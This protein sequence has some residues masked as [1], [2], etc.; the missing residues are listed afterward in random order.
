MFIRRR[1]F[2]QDIVYLDG[3]I[4]YSILSVKFPSITNTRHAYQW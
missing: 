3:L 1:L 2:Q 4:A